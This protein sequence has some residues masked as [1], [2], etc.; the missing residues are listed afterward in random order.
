MKFN[1]FSFRERGCIVLFCQVPLVSIVGCGLPALVKA[2]ISKRRRK[3]LRSCLRFRKFEAERT[4]FIPQIWKIEVCLF[5]KFEKSKRSEL[6]LFHKLERSKRSEVCLFHKFEDYRL[7]IRAERTRLI[8][9]VGKIEGKKTGSKFDFVL[10][11]MEPR[12]WF[13][14]TNSEPEPIFLNV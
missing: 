4:L 5:H 3:K 14:V 12:I 10:H 6:C 9:E 1:L 8:P 2:T 7:K 11:V 13:Q